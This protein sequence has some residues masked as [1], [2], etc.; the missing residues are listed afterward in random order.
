MTARERAKATMQNEAYTT[1]EMDEFL[2][3]EPEPELDDNYGREIV[4]RSNNTPNGSQEAE[5]T[6]SYR[7][8]PKTENDNSTTKKVD[9]NGILKGKIDNIPSLAKIVRIFTSSTFTGK[10][11]VIQQRPGNVQLQI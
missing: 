11:E 9:T 10:T 1:E 5:S 7:F 4:P 3:I 8:S 6:F 2:D